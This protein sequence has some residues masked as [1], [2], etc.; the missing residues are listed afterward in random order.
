MRTNTFIF[1]SIIF[2]ALLTVPLL[3]SAKEC[4]GEIIPDD[5]LC[6]NLNYPQFGPDGGFDLNKNQNLQQIVAYFYYFIIAVAGIAAFVMLVWGGV[7][8]LVSG[9]LPAQASDARDKIRNALLGL[10]VVLGS[11]LVIQLINPE[12][13]VIGGT[14]LNPVPKGEVQAIIFPDGTTG[15]RLPKG[16]TKEGVYL[17]KKE[18]CV[19]DGSDCKEGDN[20]DDADYLFVDPTVWGAVAG[21]LE[22]GGISDLGKWKDKAKAVAVKGNYGMLLMDDE[23]YKGVI[24]C[25]DVSTGGRLDDYERL[26][27]EDEVV[28]P[29]K[30]WGDHGAMSMKVLEGGICKNPGITLQRE[31]DFWKQ[32]TV[33]LFDAIKQGTVFLFDAIKQGEAG[34]KGKKSFLRYQVPIA[35]TARSKSVTFGSMPTPR[36]LHITL[37]EDAARLSSSIEEKKIC[38]RDAV[39]DFQKY[40]WGDPD[41]VDL[42]VTP[43]NA[44]KG[45]VDKDCPAAIDGIAQPL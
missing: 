19:C 16:A 25:L 17:C 20:P 13:L 43:P 21:P 44:V 11:Y 15:T 34:E 28:M 3:I 22:P 24:V 41:N 10:I 38:F 30:R 14:A 6:L 39:D 8:W 1:A 35:Y 40:N 9:A 12:F 7:Q 5:A 33:F 29:G 45:I 42:I 36:S 26:K 18:A 32:Q 4:N 2:I 31:E 37:G 27:N 23:D